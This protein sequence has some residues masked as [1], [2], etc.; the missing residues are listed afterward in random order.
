MSKHD[1]KKY[2]NDPLGIYGEWHWNIFTD[3]DVPLIFK[4]G[5]GGCILII[6]S[7]FIF[8]IYKHL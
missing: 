8:T 5:A 6:L 1:F 2:P 3:K 4:I 7:A